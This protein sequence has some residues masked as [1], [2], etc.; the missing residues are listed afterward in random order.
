MR[1]PYTCNVINRETYFEMEMKYVHNNVYNTVS[2]AEF[3]DGIWFFRIYD[4]KDG[5]TPKVS[6][7]YIISR[8]E[9]L[10]LGILIYK[11]WSAMQRLEN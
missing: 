7:L 4:L 1:T 6:A 8:V 11:N 5:S 3:A 9:D 10:E 2:I